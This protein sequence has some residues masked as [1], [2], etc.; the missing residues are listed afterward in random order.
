MTEHVWNVLEGWSKVERRS[1][2]MESTL[3]PV[4]S[5]HAPQEGGVRMSM[6][7]PSDYTPLVESSLAAGDRKGRTPAEWASTATELAAALENLLRSGTA[8]ELCG[9]SIRHLS[10]VRRQAEEDCLTNLPLAV[11]SCLHCATEIL[12]YSPPPWR[13]MFEEEHSAGLVEWRHRPL[14]GFVAVC[15]PFNVLSI[16]LSQL[17]LPLLLGN[18]VIW[19]PS[20]KGILLWRRIHGL[21]TEAGVPPR[22]LIV[23]PPGREAWKRILAHRS[24]EVLSFTGTPAALAENWSIVAS[25]L[26]AYRSFPRICAETGGAAFA[27]VH[28]SAPLEET[29]EE[30]TEGA[31]SFQGQ[32]CTAIKCILVPRS[33]KKEYIDALCA[34]FE[35]TRAGDPETDGE[36]VLGALIEA[37]APR[38]AARMLESAVARGCRVL[39]RGKTADGGWF[40]P[41]VLLEETD[42]AEALR[43]NCFAPVA[44]VYAYD[45]SKW[46]EFLGR[47]CSS[48]PSALSASIFACGGEEIERCVKAVGYGAG[49]L[50]LNR[51]AGD[52]V[53][54]LHPFGGSRRS[55]TG[56]KSHSA[57][58]AFFFSDP[59]VTAAASADRPP[60]RSTRADAGRRSS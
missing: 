43:S 34:A 17:L 52:T 29:V 9:L 4:E 48:T 39:A 36:A 41:A 60:C 58:S 27:F 21:L 1:T 54:G 31:L 8:E 19:K 56:Q 2:P 49:N 18:V 12:R 45:D 51:R 38:R 5:P 44:W 25:H 28:P 47:L 42:P 59:L 13:E 35:A 57:S 30:C 55:G 50:F 20:S 16:V 14:E 37:G 11:R 46:E 23:L 40:H 6:E 3:L 33:R 22:R 32:K 15:T 24:L 26:A 53:P 10:K 7:H